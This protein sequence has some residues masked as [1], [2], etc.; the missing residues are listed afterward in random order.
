[1]KRKDESMGGSPASRCENACMM[2]RKQWK[3]EAEDLKRGGAMTQYDVQR[4][5]LLIE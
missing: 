3:E 1:M 2:R 4:L 5:G